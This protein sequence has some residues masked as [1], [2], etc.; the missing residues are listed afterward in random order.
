MEKPL[1]P[2][3]QT[4]LRTL[5]AQVGV[6]LTTLGTLGLFFLGEAYYTGFFSVWSARVEDIRI[7]FVDR[8]S[9][10]VPSIVVMWHTLLTFVAVRRP[11]RLFLE[12]QDPRTPSRGECVFNRFLDGLWVLSA[13]VLLW[14]GSLIAWAVGLGVILGLWLAWSTTWVYSVNRLFAIATIFVAM[15][16][17]AKYIGQSESISQVSWV[18]VKTKAAGEQTL[19][20]VYVSSEGVYGALQDNVLDKDSDKLR[21]LVF[22][23]MGEILSLTFVRPR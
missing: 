14:Q 11:T 3:S 19:L 22:I 5:L 1:E 15:S 10:S 9:P 17:H 23:P 4:A 20:K 21:M 6:P 8:L 12:Q 2:S 18:Q 16:A 13:V 7:D